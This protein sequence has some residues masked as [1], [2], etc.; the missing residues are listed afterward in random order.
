M[1]GYLLVGGACALDGF[2]AG[3]YAGRKWGSKLTKTAI[4]ADGAA[5]AAV[6]QTVEAKVAPVVTDFKAEV[7]KVETVVPK[8]AEE[9]EAHLKGLAQAAT[10]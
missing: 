10:K 3:V 6:V 9:L 1:I 5:A 7:T 8:T 2:A 4:A